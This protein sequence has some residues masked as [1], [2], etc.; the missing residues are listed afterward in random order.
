MTKEKIHEGKY[1]KYF[2][3]SVSNK[4][5][6]IPCTGQQLSEASW[7]SPT[8]GNMSQCRLAMGYAAYGHAHAC[9]DFYLFHGIHF[10]NYFKQYIF[11]IIKMCSFWKLMKSQKYKDGDKVSSFLPP[12]QETTLCI[13]LF[14][15][16]FVFST[17]ACKYSLLL[18]LLF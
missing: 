11:Q 15:L 8:P 18:H 9:H 1:K 13:V 12:S 10:Y 16:S 14:F 5:G 2:K 6:T 17:S 3:A 4:F 7:G